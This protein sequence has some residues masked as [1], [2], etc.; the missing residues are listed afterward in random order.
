MNIIKFWKR[1]LVVISLCCFFGTFAA[2]TAYAW[3]ERSGPCSKGFWKN[4]ADL[5]NGLLKF[6]PNGEFDQLLEDAAVLSGDTFDDGDEVKTSLLQKGRL[7]AEQRAEQQL[8]ALL[9]NLSAG[10]LDTEGPEKC[11]RT[12]CDVL[13]TP[14]TCGDAQTVSEALNYINDPSTDDTD[15]AS[16]ADD[17]NTG[18]IVDLEASP[19]V[20]VSACPCIAGVDEIKNIDTLILDTAQFEQQH[21]GEFVNSA[22]CEKGNPQFYLKET[23][24]INIPDDIVSRFNFGV[25]DQ[26]TGFPDTCSLRRSDDNTLTYGVGLNITP[27]ELAPCQAEMVRLQN[28]DPLNVCP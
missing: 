5:K 25:L 11:K 21:E 15:A 1:S 13:E 6:Y 18:S 19:E 7:T 22:D 26:T 20:C 12:S 14:N 16:C 3:E 9:M 27:A 10:V 4:R 23:L 17:I 28:A 24:I 8:A 2:M